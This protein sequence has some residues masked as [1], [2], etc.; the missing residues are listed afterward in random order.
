MEMLIDA[1]REIHLVEVK[2]VFQKPN[3][4]KKENV[5]KITFGSIDERDLVISHASNLPEGLLTWNSSP[6]LPSLSEA[7]HWEI[8]I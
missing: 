3:K 2:K 1:A 5:T 7:L 8:R 4:K 6:G